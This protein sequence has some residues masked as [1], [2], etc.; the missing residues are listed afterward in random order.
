MAARSVCSWSGSSHRAGTRP[1]DPMFHAGAELALTPGYSG[2][3][4]LAQRVHREVIMLDQR[5][6][7]HS[8]P[9]LACPE[10]RGMADR[11]L[12]AGLFEPEVRAISGAPSPRASN[13]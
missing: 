6:T 1:P 13:D 9:S 10:V 2:V 12:G 11:L 7:G 8:E 4:P 3:A 5:G